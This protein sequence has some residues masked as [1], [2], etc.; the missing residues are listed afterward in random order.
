[1]QKA[2]VARFKGNSACVDCSRVMR[3]PGF[4]HQKGAPFLTRIHGMSDRL[5]Y[6]AEQI[7]AEFPPVKAAG[8]K[9]NGRCRG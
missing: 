7:L 5:P 4:Y 9:A 3:L 6:K 8:C 1:M 2:L